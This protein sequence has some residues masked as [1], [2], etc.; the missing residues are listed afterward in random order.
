MPITRPYFRTCRQFTDGH[1]SHGGKARYIEDSRFAKDGEHYVRGLELIQ[2]DLLALFDFIEPDDKNKDTYSYRTHALHMRT[3]I[4]VEANCKAILTENGFVKRDP[5][6]GRPLLKRNG[7]PADWDM[8][9]F[10]A[11]QRTH[12]LSDYEIMLPVW[13]GPAATK[14]R[15]PFGPW[16]NAT[17][18]SLPWWNAYN[19]AKHDRHEKF[20]SANFANLLDAVCALVAILS[21]QFHRYD[22]S[23]GPTLLAFG[24][25]APVGFDGAIGGYF[26]VHF[27][28]WPAAEQYDFQWDH[29]NPGTFQ[30]LPL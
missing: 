16:A 22:F 15:R 27:P 17:G 8:G 9:D 7:D 6:T 12:R 21:A 10:R 4:E 20:E 29:N 24:S 14:T 3:A 26:W 5:Q 11:L 1:Y 25:G 30:Q 18:N 28:T 2:K 23:P 19:H 13:K